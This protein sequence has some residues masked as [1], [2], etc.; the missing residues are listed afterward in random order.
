[1]RSLLAIS[2]SSTGTF[3]AIALSALSR[4]EHELLSPGGFAAV[5]ADQLQGERCR[6]GRIRR[7][8]RHQAEDDGEHGQVP[9]CVELGAAGQKAAHGDHSARCHSRLTQAGEDPSDHRDMVSTSRGGRGRRA[10]GVMATWYVATPPTHRGPLLTIDARRRHD[11]VAS[12]EPLL[13]GDRMSQSAHRDPVEPDEA[14]PGRSR[15][16]VLIGHPWIRSLAAGESD[17]PLTATLIA[18]P[19]TY[20]DRAA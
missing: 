17:Q 18:R 15:P 13:T 9:R 7:G 3:R 6:R 8:N 10:P 5:D 12:S 11:L 1:M 19:V 20:L 4:G 2:W 14:Y 16:G